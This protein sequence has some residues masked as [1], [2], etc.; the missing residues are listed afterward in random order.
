MRAALKRPK[1]DPSRL[2]GSQQLTPTTRTRLGTALSLAEISSQYTVAGGPYY[3]AG[4]LSGRLGRFPPYL[5][6]WV[7]WLGLIGGV[8]GYQF[9][10]AQQLLAMRLIWANGKLGTPP[11]ALGDVSSVSFGVPLPNQEAPKFQRAM[12]GIMAGFMTLHSCANFLPVRQINRLAIAS[13]MWLLGA[14]AV[15][16]FVLPGVAPKHASN[17]GVWT[18][19]VGSVA[20]GGEAVPVQQMPSEAAIAPASSLQA[21]GLP[22]TGWTAMVGLLMSQFLLLV[23]DTPS[24]MAE[25]TH[26]AARTVPKAIIFSY[27]VGCLLNFGLLLSYLYCINLDY[28]QYDPISLQPLAVPDKNIATGNLLLGGVTNGLFPVGNIFYDSFMARYNKAG[29]AV[30]CSFLIFMGTNFCCTLTTTASVR[31]MYSFARDGGFGPPAVNRVLRWVEP[32]TGVPV[33]CVI[34]F[35]VA[36]VAFETAVLTKT[37]YT[38]VIAEGAIVSNGF[39]LVYGIPPLLRIFNRHIYKPAKEFNLGRMSIPCAVIGALYAFFGVATIA[40]P[41]FKPVTKTTLNYAPVALAAAVVWSIVLFPFAGPLLNWYTGPAVSHL[42]EESQRSSIGSSVRPLYAPP[43][44][45]A[46]PAAASA[47]AL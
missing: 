5:Q 10:I 33:F 13:F 24:H 44:E 40:L 45:P 42:D 46:P 11:G 6:G 23:Y 9:Q 30:F 2:L 1:Q 16:M 35:F 39:L 18:T 28:Y 25:E 3:W 27:V 29:G 7:L 8:A 20:A 15:I 38:S 26:D 14:C 12:F 47:A 34:L 19:W 32:R 43:E 22:T 41:N 36:V 31:F 17:S 4:A 21:T 37:W